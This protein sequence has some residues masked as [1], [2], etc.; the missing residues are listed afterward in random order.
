MKLATRYNIL[1]LNPVFSHHL[2]ALQAAKFASSED[3]YYDSNRDSNPFESEL[4]YNWTGRATLISGKTDT[5]SYLTDLGESLEKLRLRAGNE[6]LF[7]LGDWPTPWLSQTNDYPPVKAA[8]DWLGERIDDDFS[9]GFMLKGTELIQFIL[10]LFWLTRGN[11][12]LPEFM[13][14]FPNYKTIL[15]ICQHG[16]VHVESYDQTELNDL[17][18]FYKALGFKPIAECYDPVDFDDFEGRELMVSE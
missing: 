18:D 4:D 8:W 5:D 15:S 7:V 10:R 3:D 2:L 9:G 17:L 1:K 12:S 6:E 13:L 16:V 14:S 11:M